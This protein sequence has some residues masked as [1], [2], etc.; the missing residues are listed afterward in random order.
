LVDCTLR[1]GPNS[2]AIYRAPDEKVMAEMAWSKNHFDELTAL[3]YL[4][5]NMREKLAFWLTSRAVAKV[6]YRAIGKKLYV[7]R[8]YIKLSTAVIIHK[9]SKNGT[10][11]GFHH[12]ETVYIARVKDFDSL[13]KVVAHELSH[14]YGRKT[15]LHQAI[16]NEADQDYRDHISTVQSGL[17]Y[18][19][20][21]DWC[22]DGL[23]EAMTEFVAQTAMKPLRN[24]RLFPFL[25]GL[26]QKMDTVSYPLHFAILM[27]FV[28]K[29][30]KRHKRNIGLELIREY[31]L[32]DIKSF[33]KLLDISPEDAELLKTMDTSFKSAKQV[34]EKIGM[35]YS[36]VE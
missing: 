19:A 3:E 10:T 36:F 18:C 31:L 7:G 25:F 13:I 17:T 20:N 14:I 29:A 28:E 35:S 32:G 23:N 6:F 8:S 15:Y 1:I 2:V 24:G 34:A 21:D 27:S 12:G 22:Y 33:L 4:M 26:H 11:I 30:N 16:W 5:P 9:L